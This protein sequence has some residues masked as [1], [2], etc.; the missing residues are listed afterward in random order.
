MLALKM[1]YVESK[2]T[3]VKDF[4]LDILLLQS[5]LDFE[6]TVFEE[7]IKNN[8]VKKNQSFRWK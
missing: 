3:D 2:A 6:F 7:A 4:Y 1:N 8:F 5:I